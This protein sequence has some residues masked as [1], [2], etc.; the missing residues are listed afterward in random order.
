MDIPALDVTYTI[1]DGRT[2]STR[3]QNWTAV[4]AAIGRSPELLTYHLRRTTR[5]TLTPMP[6]D[7]SLWLRGR[8]NPATLSARVHA[9]AAAFAA[10]PT[11]GSLQTALRG[12]ETSTRLNC[13]RCG[14]SRELTPDGT[15]RDATLDFIRRDVRRMQLTHAAP[16]VVDY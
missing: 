12:S 15:A 7:G 16:V 1:F 4:A 2:T 8:H 14:A 6:Y 11:C 5:C 3:I 13:N 9:F 10:C